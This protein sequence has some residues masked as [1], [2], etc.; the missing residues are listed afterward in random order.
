MTTSSAAVLTPTVI[1][2]TDGDIVG[3]NRAW[4][5]FGERNGLAEGY[6]AVGKNYVAVC[7]RADDEYGDRVA[8]ELRRLL[9]GERTEFT[10]VYPCHSP[11]EERWFRLYATSVSLGDERCH[12]LVHRRLDRGARPEPGTSV[13]A[14][15]APAGGVESRDRSRLVTYS[16]A[17][18]ERATD[19]I[20]AAFD[21]VGFDPRDRAT[22][23][24]EWIDPDAVNAL[25]SG[26][27]DFY[28]TF[29]VWDHPVGLTPD[30]VVV[31]TPERGSE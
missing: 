8:A 11:D 5:T 2:D 15:D 3:V 28:V 14:V 20:L 6:T 22:T 19:G 7:R 25:R 1:L 26:A 9:A 17:A 23:L 10:V 18:D 13:G 31:Y 27:A 24:Q 21:A 4:K 16:L 30:E 12:V 29:P